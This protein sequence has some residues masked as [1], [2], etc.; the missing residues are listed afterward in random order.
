MG[1]LNTLKDMTAA[2]TFLEPERIVRYFDLKPGDHVADFGAGHGYFTIPMARVVGGDGKVYAIDIQKGTLD[3]I[4]ARAKVE[5]I[6]NIETVWGN[7]EMPGGSK[8]KGR[9]IDFTVISNVL[10]QAEKKDVVIQE[11]YRI[12]R[13][14]GKLAIVEWDETPAPLGPPVNLRI[15]KETAKNLALK[16]GF[17]FE[18]EFEAGSHHYGLM[19]IKRV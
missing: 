15:K 11:A 19:F 16:A 12:L 14:G 1:F 4:R 18:K 9:F 2:N 10:F 3:I 6:L 7:L 8:I 5:N 17:E 13:E